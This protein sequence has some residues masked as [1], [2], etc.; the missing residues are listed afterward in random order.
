MSDKISVPYFSYGTLYGT[1]FSYAPDGSLLGIKDI[2]GL[3][4]YFAVYADG[5]SGT[6]KTSYIS[7]SIGTGCFIQSGSL[8]LYGVTFRSSDLNI[9]PAEYYYTIYLANTTSYQ[10]G[11]TDIKSIGSGIFEITPGVKYP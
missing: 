9:L 10:E 4:V 5:E 7:K 1:V 8:G 11:T 2:T 3:G 6:N